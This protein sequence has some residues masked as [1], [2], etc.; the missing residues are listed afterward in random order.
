MRRKTWPLIG[1]KHSV[2]KGVLFGELEIRL[3]V[4]WIYIHELRVRRGIGWR[5]IGPAINAIKRDQISSVHLA[6]VIHGD[7]RRMAVAEVIVD[8]EAHRAERDG[9]AFRVQSR[10]GNIG[11]PRNQH[12]VLKEIVGRAILLDDNHDVLNQ[13]GIAA[14]AVAGA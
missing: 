12:G 14:G 3:Y 5:A 11:L 7:E 4:G 8:G 10:L 2:A 9:L 6:S 1:L 13:R